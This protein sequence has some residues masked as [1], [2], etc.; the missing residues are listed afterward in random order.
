MATLPPLPPLP[1]PAPIPALVDD[2]PAG[3]LD[4][5]LR[6]FKKSP[7]ERPEER[8]DV[9]PGDDPVRRILAVPRGAARLDAFEEAIA[10][11]QP[12]THGHRGVALA[13]H[14]E[15]TTL[16]ER[17][18]VDL[19]LLKGRVERCAEA[20]FAAGE[21]ERAAHLLAKIGKK[22]RAAELFVAAG[23]IDELEEA[24]AAI[25]DEEGGPHLSARL[26]YERFEALFAVG[27]RK[28]ALLSLEEAARLW[29]DN[30]IYPE[31]ATRFRAR[32]QQ[33]TARL[34]VEGPAV[35]P[36]LVVV[37]SR[38]PLLIGRH[39]DAAFRVASPLVSREHLEVALVERRP[40]VKDLVRRA[41]T[42]VDGEELA[43]PRALSGAGVLDLGGVEIGYAV[44]EDALT[45]RSP[46]AEGQR[47]VAVL[48]REARVP[49]GRDDLPSLAVWLDEEGRLFALPV[50]GLSLDGEAV[51]RPLL[52]L[53]GDHLKGPGFEV[54][55]LERE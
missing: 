21:V 51:S 46:H 32:V 13:F 41:G 14:R 2:E 48:G 22:Q 23:A 31:I 39:E 8:A 1:E 52:L 5:I 11:L 27:L 3:V 30:P 49:L 33:H 4:M 26:A 25:V 55:V 53:E 54:A 44:A 47:V 28:E 6:F 9:T 45:L 36:G 42:S 34:R 16:A 38:W 37:R 17:A 10:L 12:D 19:S 24:H 43:E 18:G 7:K 15:L 50:E 40:V 35:A 20:L 29:P